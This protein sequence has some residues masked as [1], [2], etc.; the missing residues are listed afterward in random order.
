MIWSLKVLWDWVGDWN[1]WSLFGNGRLILV[2]LVRVGNHM[3]SDFSKIVKSY[4]ELHQSLVMND[5]NY[6]S[7]LNYNTVANGMK[8][9]GSMLI[10]I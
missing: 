9:C 3:Q 4:C 5:T 8:L 6:N 10:I 7:L 2:I 1:Y